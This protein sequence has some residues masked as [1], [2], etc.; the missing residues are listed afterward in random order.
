[1][2]VTL[3]PARN[4]GRGMADPSRSLADDIRGRTD[5]ELADL[6]LTRPD[7]ARPA[8]ADLTSLAAR[9]STKASVQR[10]IEVLDRGHLSALEALVVVGE[11]PDLDRVVELL[12]AAR[13]RPLVSSF[14]DDLW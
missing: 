12:G 2:V 3:A 6:V 7:L 9:A 11:P 14:V 8:P 5:A 4:Y 13:E 1:M 10:A